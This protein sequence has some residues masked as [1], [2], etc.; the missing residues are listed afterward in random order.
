MRTWNVV[1]IA[2]CI[3]ALVG[4]IFAAECEYCWVTHKAVWLSHTTINLM[5]QTAR[6]GVIKLQQLPL[7]G[8]WFGVYWDA[9]FPRLA[10]DTVAFFGNVTA[11]LDRFCE[12]SRIGFVELQIR[13]FVISTF[14]LGDSLLALTLL[15]IGFVGITSL[16]AASF[17]LFF[18]W[19]SLCWIIAVM[20]W[21]LYVPLAR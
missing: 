11:E 10:E 15:P 1:T 8:S 4:I 3:A 14:H 7:V 5:L 12:L 17:V 18:G 9:L 13:L 19:L 20:A 6:D 2:G 21:R 16:A